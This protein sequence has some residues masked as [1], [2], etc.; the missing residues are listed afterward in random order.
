MELAALACAQRKN[1][2]CGADEAGVERCF[3]FFIQIA[4][5]I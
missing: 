4:L 1:A 2:R 3:S 5:E